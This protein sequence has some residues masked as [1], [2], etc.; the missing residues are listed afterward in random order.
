MPVGKNALKRV[1][2]GGY[3]KVQT[4]APDMEHSVVTTTTPT[5]KEK[6]KTTKKNAPA[7]ATTTAKSASK[8]NSTTK[9]SGAKKPA[10]VNDVKDGFVKIAFGD[11]MPVHLL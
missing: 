7:K 5:P 2:N 3:S 1:T 6:P 4:S 10:I 8:T 11:E 9:A